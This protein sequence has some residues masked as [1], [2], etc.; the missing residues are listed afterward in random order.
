MPIVHDPAGA[1]AVLRAHGKSFFW[2]GRLL[3]ERQ[4]LQAARLYAFCRG[5]DDLADE[6]SAAA[7]ERLMAIDAALA[8][9]DFAHPSVADVLALVE[10][11]GVPL[12][13][14]RALVAA[15][16]GDLGPVRLAEEGALLRYSYGVAGTVG[17]M[18]CAVLE[19]RDPRATPYAIDLG[20]A[21]QLTNIARDVVEDAERD[22]IYLPQN[23]CGRVVEPR[24]IIQGEPEA[25]A[26]AWQ[27]IRE[28]LMLAERYY[29]SA[30]CGMVF[31]PLRVRLAIM[32]A[33]R[34]YRGI[35]ERVLANPE[36]YW[37]GRVYVPAWGKARRTLAAV[38]ALLT[39]AR[40]WRYPAD[41]EHD[42]ALMRP[43]SEVVAGDQEL[44]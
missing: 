17:Q 21:M 35:G 29:A 12:A 24:E 40:Y 8:E 42:P 14:V 41:G 39:Q 36:G 2:A 5:V 18:M 27:G 31:L 7:T 33:A 44:R 22:R 3:P 4:A 9:R 6:G 26:A 43:I 10:E 23:L 28:V 16:S 13:A 1:K 32:T 25:L 30:E 37:R 19:V 20:I 34:V 11:T 38:T 15:V